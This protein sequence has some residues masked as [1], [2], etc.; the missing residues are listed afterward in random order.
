[1][2]RIGFG[3]LTTKGGK[4]YVPIDVRPRQGWSVRAS[5]RTT[6]GM[7]AP[8]K[9]VAPWGA[10]QMVV[11][12]PALL[13][14]LKVSVVVRDERQVVVAWGSLMVRPS[15]AFLQ[16]K[17]HSMRH[18][19]ELLWYRG[20]DERPC[21]MSTYVSVDAVYTD[22][23]EWD[24]IHGEA[25][26]WGASPE[27][28]GRP[29]E[30]KVLDAF[31]RPVDVPRCVVA[32][33][34]VRQL[35]DGTHLR[36]VRYS[37]RVPHSMRSLTLWVR[38]ASHTVDD[39]FVTLEAAE[40]AWKRGFDVGSRY[41]RP[42]GATYFSWYPR[43]L[44]TSALELE[45]E[46]ED[47][48]GRLG[49]ARVTLV[50]DLSDGDPGALEQ[51][52]DSLECQTMGAWELLGY[53]G[54]ALDG[55]WRWTGAAWPG[56]GG[57]ERISLASAPPATGAEAIAI[58]GGDRVGAIEQGEALEPD[59]LYRLC[60]AMDGDGAGGDGLGAAMAYADCDRVRLDE[61]GR[62]IYVG[63][64]FKP[65]FDRMLLYT[66]G[67]TSRPSLVRMACLGERPMP[68]DLRAASSI[69]LELALR[70]V[71]SGGV[72]EHVPLV[73]CHAPAPATDEP[74]RLGQAMGTPASRQAKRAV[75][76]HLERT[77]HP[78]TVGEDSATGSGLWIDCELPRAGERPLVSIVIPNKDSARMLAACVASICE[79]STYDR[80]EI[81]IV[82]NNSVEA[83]TF[84]LYER[85]GRDPRIRLATYEGPFN[86]SA[87]CN[88]GAACA[89]GS[90]LVFL[91]ND[92]KVIEPRWLEL[93]LGPVH[94]GLAGVSGARLLFPDGLLQH[95]GAAM[96]PV[97][98]IHV[99]GYA[100][101]GYPAYLGL[102]NGHAHS[103][104]AVTGACLLIGRELFDELSGFDESYPIAFNDI[105][106]C[107]RAREAGKAVVMDPRAL[108]WHFES[109]SRGLDVDDP[110]KFVRLIHENARLAREWTAYYALGDPYY[111]HRY[112]N[113]NFFYVLGG[114]PSHPAYEE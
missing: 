4:T 28:L 79:L 17:Y 45:R 71:E 34:A 85:L 11:V 19:P 98:P 88:L 65:D 59:C 48:P 105:D 103:L 52:L 61:N 24:V 44:Q 82:E 30:F 9:V 41:K 112:R 58:A 21:G 67:Y 23:V 83:A 10:S 86:F 39:G 36:V 66:T 2:D 8:A 74:A 110:G 97:G 54:T 46:R 114:D 104:S 57:A 43:M 53:G 101:P 99:E 64:I 20:I 51:T 16:S 32:R 62:S 91:N 69:D 84:E 6:G 5:A 96:Q 38:H 14:T 72:I 27:R 55:R 26:F 40:L 81:V 13:A 102:T 106:L 31:A 111:D 56:E 47:A 1:M 87:I 49:G 37:Q 15:L 89:K 42:D 33:D 76:E 68:K 35:D 78:A 94:A 25:E 22:T 92:T 90:Y 50:V 75:G 60:E 108:L 93:M 80:Y 95:G 3:M 7:P 107:L 63:A 12:V 113:D 100:L 70:A 109:F 77:G 73:L 29:F 18:Y